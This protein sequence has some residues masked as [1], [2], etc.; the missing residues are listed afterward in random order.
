MSRSLIITLQVD[1]VK[2]SANENKLKIIDE[3]AAIQRH[4]CKDCGVHMYGRIEQV[5]LPL[6]SYEEASRLCPLC[7]RQ[8]D[9]YSLLV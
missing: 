5:W 2:V 1:K 3:S 4:A 9:S 6:S 7:E 8:A